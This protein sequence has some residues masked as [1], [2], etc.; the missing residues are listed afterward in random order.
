M[1]TNTIRNSYP[2]PPRGPAAAKTL[3][4]RAKRKQHHV[5]SHST[6]RSAVRLLCLLSGVISS[7]PPRTDACQNTQAGKAAAGPGRLTVRL[8]Y[9][10]GTLERHWILSGASHVTQ[11]DAHAA[12]RGRTTEIPPEHNLKLIKLKGQNI[13]LYNPKYSPCCGGDL[14]SPSG[15]NCEKN[16]YITLL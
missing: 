2:L 12:F 8:R 9:T 13:S 14:W 5:L 15:D 16:I 4:P 3:F 1:E 7:A 10:D 6:L 11:L